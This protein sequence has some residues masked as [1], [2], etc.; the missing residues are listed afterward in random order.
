MDVIE[1]LSI[2]DQLKIVFEVNPGLEKLN[3]DQLHKFLSDHSPTYNEN[4]DKIYDTF[5]LVSTEIAKKEYKTLNKEYW[6]FDQKEDIFESDKSLFFS[7][8]I[9]DKSWYIRFVENGIETFF[10][11]FDSIE[12]AESFLRHKFLIKLID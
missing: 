10:K 1:K 2:R 3:N 6:L 12:E 7:K 11:R 4:V 5:K 9:D 8:F